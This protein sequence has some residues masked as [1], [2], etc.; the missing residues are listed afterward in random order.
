MVRFLKI[1]A[2]TSISTARDGMPKRMIRAPFRAMRIASVMA[3]GEPDISN[4]TS[5]AL[6]VD[7]L[8]CVDGDV[9]AHLL[10]KA[11]AERVEIGGEDRR[12]ARGLGDGDREQPNRTAAEHGHRAAGE[13]LLARREHGVAERLLERRDLG[14]Q[15]LAVR[16][17]DHRLGHG[18]VARERAVAVDSE[19]LGALAEVAV[20]GAAGRAGAAG[21]VALGRHEVADRDI[22]HVGAH[23]DDGARELVAQRDGWLDA[24]SGPTVPEMDVEIRSAD[25]RRLHLDDDVRRRRAWLCHLLE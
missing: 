14:R 1:A 9:G 22:A 15:L 10:R 25:A 11:E 2:A 19:D 23:L 4:T 17:P 7:G 12:G 24:V 8:S 3:C 13:I 5:I 20:A 21:D 18:H 6:V 16:L